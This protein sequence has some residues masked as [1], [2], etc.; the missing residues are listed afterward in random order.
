[1]PEKMTIKIKD[2]IKNLLPSIKLVQSDLTRVKTSLPVNK[3]DYSWRLKEKK[4]PYSCTDEEGLLLNYIIQ[5]N[6]LKSGFEIA[7]GFGYS[8]IYSGLG[9]KETNGKLISVDCYVEEDKEFPIYTNEELQ[10]CVVS[11]KN[12]IQ[13]GNYPVGLKFAKDHA[14]LLGLSNSINFVI[15]LSPAD[16]PSI[17][18]KVTLDFVFI[19]GGH[20]DGQPLKDF[21][22]VSPYLA[23]KWAIFFHDTGNEDGISA[24]TE[25][26]KKLGIKAINLPTKWNLTLL[27]K[28]LD[29]DSIHEITNF[30]SGNNSKRLLIKKIKSV[31]FPLRTIKAKLFH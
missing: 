29:A 15:G 30:L 31:L 9:F 12:N 19:D 8:S 7:T 22:A 14:N 17:L 16:I 23:D 13:R 24:V 10:K 27:S 11:V 18:G 4:F 26:E 2:T 28:N 5:A 25:V 3:Y 6:Q 21:L 1:M 20:F